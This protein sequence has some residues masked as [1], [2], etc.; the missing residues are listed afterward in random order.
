MRLVKRLSKI[1]LV[2]V[3]FTLLEACTIYIPN[4]PPEL[5]VEIK[6]VRSYP[7]AV[8]IHGHWKWSRRHHRYVWV[9]GHWKKASAG[10]FWVAGYWKK[11]PHGWVW[12][13]GHW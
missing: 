12:I 10:R 6:P 9:Q 1:I 5:V 11:T 7:Y 8:W 13:K 2:I 3:A 4:P